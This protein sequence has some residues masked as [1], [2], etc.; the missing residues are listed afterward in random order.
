MQSQNPSDPPSAFS[1]DMSFYHLNEEIDMYG[2]RAKVKNSS[3][4]RFWSSNII[5]GG[6]QSVWATPLRIH[7]SSSYI[8]DERDISQNNEVYRRRTKVL[9][10]EL[11]GVGFNREIDQNLF[12][13]A[14]I[15]G[16]FHYTGS[17]R[18]ML[19]M[20]YLNILCNN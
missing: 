20:I 8:F 5:E 2:L 6:N 18:R 10:E 7:Q 4:V 12:T 13:V 3:I 9:R 17:A 1:T 15:H 16:D 14:F 11:R 19:S